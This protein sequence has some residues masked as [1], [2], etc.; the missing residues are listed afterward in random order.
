ME[1]SDAAG[2]WSFQLKLLSLQRKIQGAIADEK[3][4]VKVARAGAESVKALQQV[5]WQARRLGDA[6]AWLV[7]KLDRKAI[8]PL[9]ENSPVPISQ[10]G[11][12]SRGADAVSQYLASQGWGFP[13]LHDITDCLRIGDVTF[14]RPQGDS[15]SLRT[16]ELKTRLLGEES[17]SSD[18]GPLL[19][20]SVTVSFLSSPEDALEFEATVPEGQEGQ[21]PE[22]VVEGPSSPRQDRRIEKQFKRMS[23]ALTLQEAADSQIFEVDGNSTMSLLVESS[24]EGHWGKINELIEESRTTGYASV[25]IDKAF[26]YVALYSSDGVTE[27]SVANPRILDD[28]KAT[29]FLSEGG[30]HGNFLEISAIPAQETRAAQ[31]YMPFYLY[32]ISQVAIS[33]FMHGRLVVVALTNAGRIA[34]ALERDGFDVTI[35][36]GTR[37]PSDSI[38]VAIPA[39]RLR[40]EGLGFHIRESIHECKGMDFIL[41][42]ARGIRGTAQ[43]AGEEL[44][45][46]Q[47]RTEQ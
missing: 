15:T 36:P 34:E 23:K 29:E 9:A 16:V 17:S 32:P 35:P 21:A 2:F 39:E 14:V 18:E 11:H 31:L 40:F 25:C 20:Y 33:D 44:S 5:R 1:F 13:L 47:S 19:H 22:Q 30:K 10:E 7:L 8:R 41:D 26:M 24:S 38:S 37:S 43:L 42:V 4:R 45:R 46:L 12:G 27:G 28:L 3:K 6:F